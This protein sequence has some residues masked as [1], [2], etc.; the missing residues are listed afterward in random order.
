MSY[1]NVGG[2]V[3]Y[4]ENSVVENCCTFG[5]V[6]GGNKELDGYVGGIAGFSEKSTIRN[7]SNS[8]SVSSAENYVG[9]VLGYDYNYSSTVESC[10]NTGNVSGDYYVGGVA[11]CGSVKN[12]CNTGNG[13]GHGYTGGEIGSG[14]ARNCYNTGDITGN[15]AGS[16]VGYHYYGSVIDNCYFLNTCKTGDKYSTA[17]TSEQFASG[18]VA[19]LLNNSVYDGTQVWY[20]NIDNGKTPDDYPNFDGGTVYCGYRC[21]E[22]E[23]VYSNYP[24]SSTVTDH[25]FNS[26][27]FCMYCDAYQPA[28]LNSGVYEI[29][30]AGQLYWFASLVNG[31]STH[32]DFESQ[33]GAANAILVKDI[34]VNDGD[35]SKLASAQSNSLRKWSPIGTSDN[36]YTGQFDG[37]GHTISGIYFSDS[38]ADNVGLFGYTRGGADI[39]N[40]GIVN[41]Y[42]E[43]KNCVGGIL[44]RNNNSGVNVQHCFSEATVI[45]NEGVGG[46]KGS[47]YGGKIIDCYNAGSVKG[48][49]FVGSI[50]GLNTNTNGSGAM[51]NCFNAGEVIGTGN[52]NI[53]GI[54]GDGK[55]TISNCYCIS[56]KLTDTAATTKSPE[57]FASGE[58]AYLLN[59]SMTD[60][61]QVWYQNIDNGKTP[62]D[63]PKFDGGTVYYLEYKDTYSNTYSEPPKPDAFDKDDD[64]NLII[65]SYDD[66]VKLSKLIRSDYEVYGSQNYI[67]Q[68]NIK[69]SDDS[70]WLQGIGSVSENKPFN[71]TFDGNGYCI[72][73][74]NVN[75]SE[76]GG[77]FEIIGESGCVKDLLVFDCDF[78]AVSNISGGI[79]AVNN[80]TVDH[81]VSG[82]NLTSGI[83]HINCEISIDCTALNS[84]VKGDTSGG[85]A[86]KNNG[87]IKGCRNAAVV[88]GAQCGGIAGENSGKI[89]GSANNVKIGTSS[90]TIS[91][92]I[93]GK[94]GGTIESSYNSGSVNGGSEK[95]IGSIAGINGYGETDSPT[96]KNVFFIAA[97]NLKAVGTE[98]LK[99]PDET[100]KS[101]AK[102][103]DFQNDAFTD[104]LNAVS[105]DT[106]DWV[107]NSN[108]NKGYPT[109]RCSYFEYK[110]K[111]AGSNITVE[112]NMH[113]AL[114]VNYKPCT[115]DNS[116]YKELVSAL[117]GKK[118]FGKY[119]ASLTDND[120]NWIP[121]ELWCQG[122]I[123]ISVPTDG[124]NVQFA[125]IDFDGQVSYYKPDSVKD[126]VAVFTV[127]YPMSFALVESDAQNNIPSGGNTNSDNKT[128][129][130]TTDNAENAATNSNSSSP[131]KT[132]S[133]DFCAVLLT[134]L[135]SLVLIIVAKR[136]NK[137]E[138]IK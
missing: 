71:G 87:L 136:G 42:I 111:S 11:G 25:K 119:S 53:G 20:Q 92:G 74:L 43:G 101:K 89:Y 81:C 122:G 27:G 7:C 134:A 65:K 85:I 98:S 102:N 79:A 62:D 15:S 99:I 39:Y 125:G 33:N 29:S 48:A 83:I 5:A 117:D 126:G 21:N 95:S 8:G 45:G 121:V 23:K 49:K 96:V 67:L 59:N 70:E 16:I 6:S 52:S 130:N 61:K 131:I 129:D 77:L 2:I 112:G 88:S 54:R 24:L 118:V 58:V 113:G 18:E 76:Y 44:G 123:K 93:A 17:K 108:L 114:N 30:N 57:Q 64:E 86:G 50:R 104:E 3:G 72:I 82:V 14:S 115:K 106:V 94:N 47:T 68:N 84:D 133:A 128:V 97:N 13:S 19:Y 63:Y 35:I 137:V 103:S 90:S 120:G 32:A 100:N 36:S 66:L 56:T 26:N 138:K 12:C 73:G 34:V 4:A 78:K 110:V 69:A 80:G 135:L 22:T 127:P 37:Q 31:D 116:Q 28:V 10:S 51:N 46:I 55:G 132:G 75:S 109:V 40:V 41:S 60:G 38:T 91:G 124:K 1:R 9:G 105:D 107:R